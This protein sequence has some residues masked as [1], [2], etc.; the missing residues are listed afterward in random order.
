MG[1][2]TKTNLAQVLGKVVNNIAWR[3]IV[4][5]WESYRGFNE[6]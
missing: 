3:R 1:Y 6:L 4:R 5:T 2:A